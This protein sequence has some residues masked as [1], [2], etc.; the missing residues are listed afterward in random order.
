MRGVAWGRCAREENGERRLRRAGERLDESAHPAI[1]APG[2][3]AQLW[4]MTDVA[5]P[6]DRFFR[7]TFSRRATLQEFV[8][9]YLPREVVRG[10]DLR[11]LAPIEGSFV[12][13]ELR[14]HVADLVCRA[15]LSSGKPAYLYLL[16][17]HKSQPDHFVALQ[18]L[19]YMTK[20][21]DQELKQ[22]PKLP[23]PTVLPLVFYHGRR[24]WTVATEFSA[25]FEC[26]DHLAPFMPSFRYEL[27]DLS[28]YSDDQIRGGVG[29]QV[30]LLAMRHIF[31]PRPADSLP[32][33]L[34][35]VATVARTSSGLR[36][37]EAVMRYFSASERVEER[38]LHEALT[39]VFP[40]EGEKLMVSMAEKYIQE[41][42]KEGE[43]RGSAATAREDI[44]EVLEARF[45]GVPVSVAER[46]RGSE[47]VGLLRSLL[48]RAVTIES[49]ERFQ[50][51]LERV[52]EG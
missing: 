27:I 5:N 15:T 35:L 16:F 37:L 47:D 44:L 42:I 39:T 28:Q 48:K 4:G 40:D 2:Q 7:E 30:R 14:L 6:H 22:S 26:P 11:T 38:E 33:I 1:P 50:E 49:I 31:D 21:W 8:R 19:R 3:A 9:L 36:A 13:P 12:D 41:G 18:L 24:R 43:R 20:L 10:L 51:A 17:E 32:R 29:L 23:L 46:I 52:S 34:R 45:G 25:L